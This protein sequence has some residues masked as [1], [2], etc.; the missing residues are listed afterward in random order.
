[1]PKAKNNGKSRTRRRVT[2]FNKNNSNINYTRYGAEEQSAANV[3]KMGGLPLNWGGNENNG[4]FSQPNVNSTAAAPVGN[5][6]RFN[7]RRNGSMDR[8]V[9][10][11][12]LSNMTNS[13]PEVTAAA[14]ES[15]DPANVAALNAAAAPRAGAGGLAPWHV[16][17]GPNP[18]PRQTLHHYPLLVAGSTGNIA[19]IDRMTSSITNKTTS[20]SEV[21]DLLSQTMSMLNAPERFAKSGV[22]KSLTQ[23]FNASAIA[24]GLSSSVLKKV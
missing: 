6:Q 11:F 7:I 22:Q 13:R 12:N 10:L 4:V 16:A 14:L 2:P 17:T 23:L 24:F 21:Y 19:E 9:P 18:F 8:N 15:L 20:R 3:A 1:M 5:S